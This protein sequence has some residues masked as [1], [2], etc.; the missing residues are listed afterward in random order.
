MLKY[1]KIEEV[2]EQL[3]KI[4]KEG[5]SI[6]FVPTMGALHEGHLALVRE[7]KEDNDY[8]VV[9]IFVNPTQFNNKVDLEKYP[10]A[11]EEDIRLLE[12]ENCDLLFHPEVEEMYPDGEPKPEEYNVDGLD[13]VL[14]GEHRPGHFNGVITVVKRLFEIVHPSRAYFGMKD[15]QQ[16]LIINTFVKNYQIP[17]EIIPVPIERE[18]DGLAMSSRNRRL[19]PAERKEATILYEVLKKAKLRSGFQTIEELKKAT[20][21]RFSKSKIAE[22]EYFELVDLYTL[23]PLQ[24]W[25]QS[26][27][28]IALLAARVGDIRLIDNMIIYM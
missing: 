14:E 1:K 16:L 19:S 8:V 4:R 11:I 3:D 20:T 12:N 26:S 25:A 6:G 13:K 27:H 18:E 24:T 22:L 23:K 5:K 21:K 28:V 9:S 2:K 10:R 17:V 7:A 15:Y